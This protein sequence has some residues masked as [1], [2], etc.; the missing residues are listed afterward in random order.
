MKIEEEGK[1]PYTEIGQP[2]TKLAIKL[3]IKL[4]LN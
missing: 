2:S 4:A 1:I 3:A